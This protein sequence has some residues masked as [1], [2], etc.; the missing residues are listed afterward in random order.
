MLILSAQK[1]INEMPHV[2]GTDLSMCTLSRRGVGV[3]VVSDHMLSVAQGCFKRRL[4]LGDSGLVT[5]LLSLAFP[6]I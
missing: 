6:P 4:Y 3:A 2:T 5:V 1:K